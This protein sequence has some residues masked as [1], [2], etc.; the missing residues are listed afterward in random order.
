MNRLRKL[1]AVSALLASWTGSAAASDV[2]IGVP[3]WSSATVTAHML[4]ALLKDEFDLD[5]DLAEGTNEAIFAAMDAGT[6]DVHPEVW[7]PNHTALN[8]EYVLRR[9]SVVMSPKGVPARQGICV[10]QAT[11]ERGIRSV[12]D[13]ADPEKAA[14]FDTD[15]NGKGE[16]WIGAPDWSS[17]RIE[18]IRARSYGY[19]QT[20]D[21]LEADEEVAVTAIDAAMASDKPLVFFCYE[22]HHT[23]ELHDIV[24]LDEPAYDPRKWTVVTPEQDPDWLEKSSAAVAW[25]PSFFHINYSAKLAQERPD[26][27]AFLDAIRLD[28]DTVS[29][30]TYALIVE[31]RD[32][33]DFAAEWIAQNEDRISG[34]RNAA[35]Q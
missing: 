28:V 16:I 10:T 33:D 27:A 30:M 6:E 15:G 24:F 31:R 9:K 32:P 5:V 26:V 25:P 2:V 13:L 7:L 29:E 3:D 22:P 4:G 18:R 34:W 21:L 1:L 17:T 14:L 20:M 12:T 19:D 11:R 23:F 8:A 35:K